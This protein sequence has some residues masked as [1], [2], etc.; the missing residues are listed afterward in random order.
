MRKLLIATAF[1]EAGAGLAL[2]VFPSLTVMLLLGASL[3]SAVAVMLGR[4]AGAALFTLGLA[5]WLARDDA[6]SRAARGLVAAMMAYNLAVVVIFT[7]ADLDLK[8]GGIALWPAVIAHG[9][10]IVWRM[11]S[12]RGGA[13]SEK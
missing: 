11:A 6:Q 7:F 9:A 2:L 8:M 12:L 1:I 10:M 3:D 13:A 4:V 5:C